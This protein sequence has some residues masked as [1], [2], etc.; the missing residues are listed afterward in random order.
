MII[1]F[2]STQLD[3][4]VSN[5][6]YRHRAIKG[7][8][9]LMLYYS[10]PEHIEIPLGAYCVF[11]GETYT[12]E[13]PE[14]FKERDTRNFEYTLILDSAQAKLNKY[15]FKDTT[16]RRLKFSLTAKPHEHLQMLVD[17]LNQREPGWTVGNC[18]DAVEKV[19]SYNHAY[20]NDALSQIAD[21][22]E[23]EWEVVGKTINLCK[24]EYNKDNPLPLSY[25]RGKGFRSGVGRSNTN[26]KKPVEI[27]FV[28]GGERNID[29]SK[30]GSRELLLPKN[31]TIGYD[32]ELFS[33][34][35]G[36]N[37][38]KARNYITD[39]DGFSL[40]RS[41]KPLSS[42]AEDSLDCSHIYPSRVGTISDVIVV[43]SE[44]NFYDF[45][46]NSIPEDLDFSEYRI[47][48]ETMTIIF[49][50]GMLTGK[51]FNLEQTDKIVTGYIHSERRFKLV[52]QEIDGRTMPDDVFAP[53]VGQ[54][55]AVFGMMM[56]E[57]YIC[58]NTT[59][60][61]ASWDMFREAVKF[62]F[63]NEEAKFTFTGEL[64][65][66]WAKKNWLNIGGK[67]KLGGYVL[68]SDNH[69]QPDGV[70]IRIVGIKDYINNPHSPQIEL[71]NEIVGNSIMSS[72]RKIETNEVVT[73]ALHRDSIQYTKRSFRSAKETLDMLGDALLEGFTDSISPITIQTM[74]MLVG[75]ESL[76]FRFVNNKTNPVTVP[77]NISFD[78][79]TK[80]LTSSAGII[81]HMTL[82]ITAITSQRAV[83]EYKF[84][85]VSEYNSPPLTD[86]SKRYYLYAKVEKEGTA[87]EF[88]LSETAIGMESVSGY[89]HLLTGILNS[90][91]DGE[92]SYVDLYGFTEVLPGRI[93]ADR[94]ISSDGQCFLDFLYNKF[95][96]G[97]QDSGISWNHNNDRQIVL[98]GTLVQSQTGDTQ[99]LGYFRGEYNSS[100][101]YYEGD[102]V[103]YEGST[104][105]YIYPTSTVGNL[106]S[107]TTYWTVFAQKG[108]DGV[109]GV[110]GVNG[111]DGIGGA[112]NI[113]SDGQVFK[114]V[115]SAYTGTPSP[116]SLN[117][118]ADVPA[119]AGMVTWYYLNGIQEIQ[120]STGLT[121]LVAY[122]ATYLS[123]VSARTI[124]AKCTWNGQT[125][126]DEITIAK[127]GDG[128][129]GIDGND[130]YTVLLTNESHIVACDANGNPLAGELNSS[131]ST[132]SVIVYRG[133]T[134]FSPA[135]IPTVG[136]YSITIQSVIGCTATM[137]GS[138]VSVSA[139]SADSAQINILINC[140]GKQ[141][142]TKIMNLTKSRN[143]KDGQ[144]GQ[145][146]AYFE[147]RYAKNGSTTTPP[148]L[149]IT[150][151]IPSGWDTVIP[152]IGTL[153]YLWMTVAKKSAAGALLQNWSTPIR[154]NGEKG[155]AGAKGDVGPSIVFRGEY[156]STSTYYSTSNR[157]DVVKYNG[158]YYVARIDAGNGFSGQAPTNTNYWNTFGA[159]FESVATN[160]LLAEMA[161][162]GD[163]II[164]NGKITSQRAYDDTL[165]TST[166]D[167][168]V[169][170]PAVQ[171]NGDYG[172]IVL[173]SNIDSDGQLV[174]QVTEIGSQLRFEITPKNE[175]VIIDSQ[176]ITTKKAGRTSLMQGSG[177]IV[178]TPII[179]E[180]NG[181]MSKTQY[182]NLRAIA[183]IV[184]K[185]SNPASNPVPTFGGW[186][187]KLMVEGLYL[188]VQTLTNIFSDV[189]YW[190]ADNDVF[191]VGK[192]TVARNVYLI[193]EQYVGKTLFVKRAGS[194][195]LNLIPYNSTCP[196]YTNQ[197]IAGGT[198]WPIPDG[199]IIMCVWD[200]SYW[201][202]SRM[203]P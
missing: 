140:E 174:K 98:R 54:Q 119:G 113:V 171:L 182:G 199:N 198:Y 47:D 42:G 148:A 136:Y 194:G 186:F 10:L 55:Y 133:T 59:K 183:G 39:A 70:P 177:Y 78:N 46:D 102:L 89:Y 191:I 16:T 109:D 91:M 41:D 139:M 27:L 40:R 158:I 152:S 103:S 121:L 107:N 150:A 197:A 90:E 146:G 44:K 123:G 187:Q 32:G 200:G 2:N 124:R 155:D 58:D 95:R 111:V 126:Q 94:I 161:N 201:Q 25:G 144:G 118:R 1:H 169:K 87:G 130:A 8:H 26:D 167:I 21:E 7:E 29:A 184:G 159:Q 116:A 79:E 23:T 56:P 11:E 49:Q 93:T 131:K 112:L 28:Q 178:N 160:L 185:A 101:T 20:C 37:S 196:M 166:T 13:S 72:L 38:A 157:V 86:G 203:Q 73:E 153:E 192:N 115:N 156:S 34:Q 43:D 18:I 189:S 129:D 77:H 57:A 163:W 138:S 88:V 132:T 33:D 122:N 175:F 100:Y 48:G 143:G 45:T 12:L 36:F 53:Q 63:E 4:E 151:A 5:N 31:Q 64:D 128:I 92:R 9:S 83:G 108:E 110:D 134:Q 14:N 81:Q 50:S 137:V 71:S 24:V 30:Y 62:M 6:S 190:P 181:N 164:K 114:Y 84:W 61:G 60:S 104:Y 35:A 173:A 162:I 76:Q 19:I 135:S 99:P 125:L 17:N 141:S 145:D 67:I 179:A 172:S 3:L 96:I 165:I 106:P 68:F 149:S 82:G 80:I 147:Y 74:A 66:I 154:A 195:V 52:P 117:L 105:R 188:G 69:F 193:P 51:E 176:G 127:L 15:K 120:I 85:D 168:G 180:G 65:G 75:D 97:D 170:T 22:F 142:F 202:I